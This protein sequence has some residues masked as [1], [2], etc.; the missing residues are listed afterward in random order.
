MNNNHPT[1]ARFLAESLKHCG[2]RDVFFIDAILRNTL[3]EMEQVGIKRVLV[4]SEK[5][6]AYMADGYARVTN[7]IGVCMAQS[8]GAANL[9][10]GLQDAYLHRTPILALTGRKPPMYRYRNAYQE[11]QHA[12]MFS[13]VTKMNATVEVGDQ[14]PVLLEQALREATTGTPRP[15]HLDINGLQGEVIES[16]RLS[17][18]YSPDAR[19]GQLPV[20][21]PT[22]DSGE[23]ERAAEALAKAKKP[24]LVIGTGAIQ[25]KAHKVVA[26]LAETL[27][28][29]V[30]T[31]LGGR[32]IVP[33]VH[34]Y[35]IGV[36][37]T[38]SAPITNQLV[39]EA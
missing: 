15:V 27:H 13:A 19:Y 29:P 24:V 10:A 26:K 39:H 30:A 33:T 37:G 23:V 12:P 17:E 31:S 20:H 7:G 38:Y 22:P 14:L 25:A 32:S 35:H 18:P 2:V 4:H 16:A 11:I 36:V 6:A 9:A 34:H 21:R 28:I 1:G 5:T 8:V 3:L